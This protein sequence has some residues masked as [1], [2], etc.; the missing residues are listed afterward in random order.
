MYVFIS[1]CMSIYASTN[2]EN[3][4]DMQIIF[5]YECFNEKRGNGKGVFSNH[6]S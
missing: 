1:A 5:V 4:Y 3:L 2:Y 6:N